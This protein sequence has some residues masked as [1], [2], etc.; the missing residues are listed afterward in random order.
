[1]ER[2]RS[3]MERRPGRDAGHC[4]ALPGLLSVDP[5]GMVE[6]GRP[7][8]NGE[9]VAVK[10]LFQSDRAKMVMAVIGSFLLVLAL[11]TL[12]YLLIR[13]SSNAADNSAKFVEPSITALPTTG[14]VPTTTPPPSTT[15]PPAT[16]TT[17]KR[18]PKPT[19]T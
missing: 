8:S 3:A 7:R 9:E 1:M 17:T 12:G 15:T 14:D 10:N 16:K 19:T 6:R 11:G 18:I 5:T 2:S 13:P 4:P